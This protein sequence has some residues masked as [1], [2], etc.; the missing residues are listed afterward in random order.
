VIKLDCQRLVL[1]KAD[2]GLPLE[3]L[4]GTLHFLF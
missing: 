4:F 1:L 3:A 2:S